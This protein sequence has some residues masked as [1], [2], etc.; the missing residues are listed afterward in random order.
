MPFPTADRSPM[1]KQ[2][3]PSAYTPELGHLICERL[4]DGETLTAIC[5]GSDMPAERTV[6]RWAL[7][8]VGGFAPQYARAR[9]I[10]YY[11]MAD[12]IIDIADDRGGDIIT[13]SDG[14]KRTDHDAIA[15]AR[16]RVDSR[17]C[18]A[19]EA[20]KPPALG[21]SHF[22]RSRGGDGLPLSS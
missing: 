16:L 3:R 15:R 8:D 9:E 11:A 18:G 5:K 12:E 4:T 6:R 21:C 13:D 10:G 17:A 14:S 22:S 1:A 20:P 2:G 19:W 7:D